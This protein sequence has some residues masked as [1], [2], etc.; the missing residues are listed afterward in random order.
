MRKQNIGMRLYLIFIRNGEIE[1]QRRGGPGWI[2]GLITAE[3]GS[4]VKSN[5]TED[6]FEK[7]RKAFFIAEEMGFPTKNEDGMVNLED[8]FD[9]NLEKLKK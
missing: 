6:Y 9:E 2:G 1:E 4:F 5:I 7:L 3:D 8:Y